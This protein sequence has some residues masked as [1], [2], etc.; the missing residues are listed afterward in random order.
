MLIGQNVMKTRTS[1]EGTSLYPVLSYRFSIKGSRRSC[2]L[3]SNVMSL[4]FYKDSSREA[5]P[6]LLKW[7]W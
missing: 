1:G 3:R 7:C 5:S 4:V 2:K 6:W